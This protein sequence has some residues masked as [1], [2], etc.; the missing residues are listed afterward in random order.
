MSDAQM[1]QDQ[2]H[3]MA[4][5]RWG[6]SGAFTSELDGVYQVGVYIGKRR[7]VMG[8]GASWAEA[9]KDARLPRVR[10]YKNGRVVFDSS[11]LDGR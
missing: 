4:A 1:T 11:R 2:L 6:R 5:N 7:Q 9:A 3:E 8:E 10:R